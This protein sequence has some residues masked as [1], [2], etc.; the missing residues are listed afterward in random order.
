[1]TLQTPLEPAPAP[2]PTPPRRSPGSLAVAIGT[3]VIGG[4]VIV[5][6]LLSTGFTAARELRSSDATAPLQQSAVDGVRD[7]DIEVSGGALTVV[8]ADVSEAQL[9]GSGIGGWTLEQDGDTLKVATPRRSFSDWG[10]GAQA[11]LTLPQDLERTNLDLRVEVAGGS[12]DLA[13]D[14]G[15]VDVQ[16]AGGGATVTGSASALSI[17]VSGGSATAD[18]EGVDAATFEVTGGDLVADLTGAAPARTSIEVTA[19]S[20]DIGLPDDT[21]RV[22][23]DGPG[24]VDSSLKT[25]PTAT[26]RID[27]QATLGSVTLRTT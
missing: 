7:L 19:G 27:V 3:I 15:D 9:D 10:N 4:F 18:V 14:Y 5:G 6:T 1:M 16:V 24:S 25:S 26:P 12:L 11:T 13:G 8:F 21:Y 22:S 2:V 23:S 17:S 20:A